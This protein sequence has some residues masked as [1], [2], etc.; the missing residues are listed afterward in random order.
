M[1]GRQ[2]KTFILF[3]RVLLDFVISLDYMCRI[4][5]TLQRGRPALTPECKH[6][7]TGAGNFV[8]TAGLWWTGLCYRKRNGRM[9]VL[10]FEGTSVLHTCMTHPFSVF[11]C[12]FKCKC[13]FFPFGWDGQ[14]NFAETLDHSPSSKAGAQKHRA[15]HRKTADATSTDYKWSRKSHKSQ[16]AGFFRPT[17]PKASSVTKDGSFSCCS[18]T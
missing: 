13:S 3:V 9:F 5:P 17:P 7:C 16:S 1:F 11:S 14:N 4:R 15:R 18:R 10:Q 12:H 2:L 6:T 8:I